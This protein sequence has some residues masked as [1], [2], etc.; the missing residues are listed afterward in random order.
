MEG[1]PPFY[2]YAYNI[3]WDSN[4]TNPKKIP[5]SCKPGKVWGKSST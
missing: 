2:I 3:I 1:A 5:D 4:T